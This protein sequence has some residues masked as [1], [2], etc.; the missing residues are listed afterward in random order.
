KLITTLTGHQDNVSAVA[1]SPDGS[2]LAT[3]SWDNTARVWEAKTGKLITTLTGHQDRV[4]EVAFSPDGT[5]LA[6]ASSDNT[7]RVWDVNLPANP[8]SAVCALTG[9]PMS[10]EN[11]AQ[12]LPGESYQRDVCP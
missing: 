4:W 11:W 8:F 10:K 12:Y 2:R 6:T 9:G 5:R 7:A 1:F 3:A